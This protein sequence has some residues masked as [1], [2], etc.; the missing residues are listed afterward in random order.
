M[1]KKENLKP[2]NW[3][4]IGTG[5]LA[6]I[7]AKQLLSSGRHKILSCYTRNYDKGL[8]FASSF[9]AKAYQTPEEAMK[10]EGVDGVYI[11]TPHNAH[12]RYAKMAL[13]LDLPTFCEKPF[14]VKAEETNELI[15]LARSRGVFLAEA[16]W[17]WYSPAANKAREWI[18][19]NKLGKIEY[20]KF[21]YHMHSSSYAPRVTDPKR[22]GGAL[23]DIG[24]YPI[25]Y[26]YR[27]FGKPNTVDAIG[28]IDNGIDTSDEIVF[29]YDGF[30]VHISISIKD[31]KGLEK[32]KIVGE[33]GSLSSY[34]YHFSNKLTYRR[35][36][37]KREVFRGKGPRFNSYVD[38]FD[39]VVEDIRQGHIESSMVPLEATYDVMVLMDEIRSLI[40]LEYNELE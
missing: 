1:A 16:M 32:M 26:A 14:T 25:T 21:T 10:A 20:V 5:Q 31:W 3:Y 28:W 33:K 35:G 34:F 23:L 13:L 11:V 40:G 24:V 17:T 37:L 36:L 30:D 18:I 8:A 2:F 38:E 7:V 19:E 15:R 6:H 39:S 4:F 12:F 22:A 29:H 9:G 27:L